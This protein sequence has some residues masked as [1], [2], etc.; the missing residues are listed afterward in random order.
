VQRS[1][2]RPE[3]LIAALLR[4]LQKLAFEI[5]KVCCATA[6]VVTLGSLISYPD[7][8]RPHEGLT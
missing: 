1:E 2:T 7:K 6:K 5:V 3:S 4:G 8:S